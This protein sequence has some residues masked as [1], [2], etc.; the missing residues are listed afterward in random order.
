MYC[1]KSICIKNSSQLNTE[2]IAKQLQFRF[3]NAKNANCVT[4]GRSK[5]TKL[6]RGI[7]DSVNSN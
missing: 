6:R 2:Y 4:H 3:L 7:V 5:F 1:H